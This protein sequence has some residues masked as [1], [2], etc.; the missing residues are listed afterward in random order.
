MEV[1]VVYA[2]VK[3]VEKV[4]LEQINHLSGK[5]KQYLKLSFPTI[6]DLVVV[7]G[8]LRSKIEKN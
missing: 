7:R 8:Q 6:N 3:I 2:L 1:F 5:V 4:D